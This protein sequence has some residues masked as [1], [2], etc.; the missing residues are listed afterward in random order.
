MAAARESDAQTRREMYYQIEEMFFGYEGLH[1]MIPLMLRIDPVLFKPW[2]TGPFE[3]DGL[4]GGPH[5]D[6]RSIDQE[7]QLAARGN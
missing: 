5:Y 4:F 7:A 3:T 1:P 6:W 2:Y